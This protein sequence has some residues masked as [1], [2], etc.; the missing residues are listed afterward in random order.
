[1]HCALQIFTLDHKS[2]LIDAWY[3]L[4]AMPRMMSYSPSKLNA[5]VIG[6]NVPT[7]TVWPAELTMLKSLLDTSR[8]WMG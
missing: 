7:H 1:M 2:R 3:A 6:W 8:G 4:N 5:D